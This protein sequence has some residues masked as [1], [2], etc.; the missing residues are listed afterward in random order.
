MTPLEVIALLEQLGTLFN[1]GNQLVAAAQQMHPE[2][3]TTPI[4]DEGAAMD[5]ARSEA[6]K[7]KE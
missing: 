4:A 2:L 3:R 7:R 5:A 6:L 1:L